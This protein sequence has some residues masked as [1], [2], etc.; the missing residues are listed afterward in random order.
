[1]T[2]GLTHLHMHTHIYI[3]IFGLWQEPGTSFSD[4]C[5]ELLTFFTRH[6]DARENQKIVY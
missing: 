2:I 4:C 6:G 3:H 5:P 1:M